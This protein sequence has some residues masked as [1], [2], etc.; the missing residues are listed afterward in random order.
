MTSFPADDDKD[1]HDDREARTTGQLDKRK[2]QQP[3]TPSQDLTSGW[4]QP[5]SDNDL[6]YVFTII[7]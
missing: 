1:A 7:I 4:I 6:V 5:E 3:G 2:T